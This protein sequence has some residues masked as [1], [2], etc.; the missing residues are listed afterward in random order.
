LKVGV[1]GTD[2]LVK[3]AF[4]VGFLRSRECRHHKEAHHRKLVRAERILGI[5]SQLGEVITDRWSTLHGKFLQ[6]MDSEE[7]SN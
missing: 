5:V 3:A 1:K 7:S 6:M 2:F 4:E